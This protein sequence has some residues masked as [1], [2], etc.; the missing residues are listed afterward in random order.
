[1]SARSSAFFIVIVFLF[2]F[3]APAQEPE[4]NWYLLKSVRSMNETQV[5]TAIGQIQS[6]TGATEVWYNGEKSRTYGCK[7]SVP[8][9]W[10]A[11][12]A[13]FN[14]HNVFIA[15]ITRGEIH[16]QGNEAIT[17]IFYQQALY[18]STYP[19]QLQNGLHFDLN[20]DEWD[21]LPNNSKQFFLQQNN[22][23]LV[24]K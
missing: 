7:K 18:Y 4:M 21:A 12:I 1:M 3:S 17:S 10:T 22:Y 16:H 11:V 2:A 23:S 9:Q 13:N 8:I 20:Q 5:K 19:S 6:T 14:A 15:D 24:N